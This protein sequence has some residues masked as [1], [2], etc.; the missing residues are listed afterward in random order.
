[1]ETIIYLVL[2]GLAAGFMGGMVGIGGGVIMFP[3]W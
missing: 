2:I 3:H 1:M